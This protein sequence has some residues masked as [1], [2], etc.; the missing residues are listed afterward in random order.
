M[1]SMHQ[2]LV[3]LLSGSYNRDQISGQG[4]KRSLLMALFT[5][6]HPMASSQRLRLT[7]V[8]LK[9]WKDSS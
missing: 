6:R 4:R 3:V 9:I 7:R 8:K 5:A 1:N 2:V